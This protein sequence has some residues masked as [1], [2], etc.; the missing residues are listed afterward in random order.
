MLKFALFHLICCKIINLLEYCLYNNERQKLYVFQE[1]Y[2]T[3][4][5]LIETEEMEAMGVINLLQFLNAQYVDIW[6]NRK[7]ETAARYVYENYVLKVNLIVN[8]TP[9]HFTYHIENL[10]KHFNWEGVV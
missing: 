5:S 6:Y 7:S 9:I 1:R 3:F 4:L 10:N 2:P 8:T